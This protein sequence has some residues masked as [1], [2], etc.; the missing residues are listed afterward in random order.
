MRIEKISAFTH[1]VSTNK[2]LSPQIEKMTNFGFQSNHLSSMATPKTQKQTDK[3]RPRL[4]DQSPKIK[5]WWISIGLFLLACMAYFNTLNHGF[6]LDDPLAIQLNS[7]VTLGLKGIGDIIIGSYREANFGGQLY[8]PVSLIQ[9][10]VEW[11]IAP[12]NPAIHH[13]FNIFWYACTVVLV[14]IVSKRWLS[15]APVLIPLIIAA[16]FAVHPIHTEVV[17]NIKSRDEIMSLFFLLTAFL[18]WDAYF[19]KNSKV[20]L[21]TAVG[22]YF[23]SLISK[24]TA[25]TMFPVFGLLSWVIYQKN[26]KESIINGALFLIP[27]LLL[28]IIRFMLFSGQPVPVVDIMDNP[29]VGAAGYGQHVAT[30][31]S[32]LLR[33]ITLL[34]YP[35]PLSCDYSYL[36]LPLK[37]FSNFNVWLSILLH[38]G[39]LVIGIIQIGKK[40]FIGL[41]LMGYLLSIALF[42]QIFLVIGTMFGERLAYLASFWFVAGLVYLISIGLQ[43]YQQSQSSDKITVGLF[44]PIVLVFLFLTTNRNAAWESNYTLFTRDVQTY[45]TSVRLNNGAAEE[46]VRLHDNTEDLTKKQAMLVDAEKYCNQIM[47]IKPVATAYLTLGNIRMRQAQYEAAIDYYNQV[48]DLQSIVDKN[49]ALAYRELGRQAG[50]KENNIAKAQQNLQQSLQLNPDDAETWSILGVS[51]GVTGDHAKAAEYFDKAYQL[52]PVLNYAKNA[53]KAYQNTENIE[54]YKQYKRIVE[55]SAE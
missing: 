29:I 8:R 18:S 7:N 24:E 17:A 36:V 4:N 46:T 26:T 50:E 51:Y 33:Y 2:F 25:I 19:R 28:F 13:F 40:S 39:L 45:P 14:F 34:L 55:Q 27:V 35:N 52:N 1:F 22:L 3:H 53:L 32:I 12:N 48:N 21:W 41:V 11:Q 10:A 23:I 54:K 5:S 43:K 47:A 44:S 42:S 6:V 15:A 38:I 49:L 30:A 37:D 16:L 20:F 31:M 9:F